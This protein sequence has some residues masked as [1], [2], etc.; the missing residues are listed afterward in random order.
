MAW[1]QR[2]RHRYY[3]RKERV[4]G[5]VVSRYVGRGEAGHRAAE[6]DRHLRE[7]REVERAALRA[8]RRQR[9]QLDAEMKDAANAARDLA[10]ALLRA[11]GLYQHRGQWRRRHEQERTDGHG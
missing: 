7:L 4:D 6:A 2:G 10:T 5:R 1:E 9:A 8:A 3:Y 11:E